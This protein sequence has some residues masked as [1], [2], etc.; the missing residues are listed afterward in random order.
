MLRSFSMFQNNY[1]CL[2]RG[3][4]FYAILQ[5][6]NF[7]KFIYRIIPPCKKCPYKMGLVK[8]ILDPCPYCK[9][10]GYRYFELFQKEAAGQMP[11][12]S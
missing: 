9:A 5:G 7:I 12:V 8:F 6:V 3:R 11:K 4:L 1:Q 2:S 10:N